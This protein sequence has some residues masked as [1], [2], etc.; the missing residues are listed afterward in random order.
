MGRG[1]MGRGRVK[2]AGLRRAWGRRGMYTAGV[3][4]STRDR[5][6]GIERRVIDRGLSA[7]AVGRQRVGVI[8]WG[9]A[10]YYSAFWVIGC[11]LV[12]VCDLYGE[13]VGAGNWVGRYER[14]RQRSWGRV[15]CRILVW[16]GLG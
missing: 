14:K 5:M 9:G 8:E 2:V 16:S 15:G 4:V 12:S 13:R 7:G 3:G 1:E 10:G 6:R 11:R